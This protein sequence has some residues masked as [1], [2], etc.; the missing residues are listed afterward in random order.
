M[1]NLVLKVVWCLKKI[2]KRKI[3][4]V[5]ESWVNLKGPFSRVFGLDRGEAIDRRFMEEFLF[6]HQQNIQGKVLE[7]GDD[8]FTYQFGVG[9]EST[10]ILA[11]SENSARSSCFPYPS[12]DLTSHQSLN[13]IGKYDCVI[14][15][16]VLNFIYDV[17]SAIQGLAKLTSQENGVLLA[18]VAGL[19][20]I[21]RYDYDR[22]G[23]YWRFNDLSIQQLF[24][25]YFEEVE[26]IAYG[27]APLAAAFIMGLAQ[28]E[29]PSSLFQHNDPDYQILIGV[30]ATKPRFSCP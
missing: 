17:K 29:V 12:Y 3:Y 1:A 18:S 11:G 2:V 7:I 30:K 13:S 24:E 6:S 19:V 14:A 23:D 8:R 10:A 9:L 16:N 26:V 4:P 21:S 25:E 28:E 15:T 27:N 20:P 5:D 22:W